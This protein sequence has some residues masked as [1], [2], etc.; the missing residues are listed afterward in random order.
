MPSPV[1]RET[2]RETA[3]GSTRETARETAREKARETARGTARE[4]TRETARESAR[5]TARPAASSAASDAPPP[6][7]VDDLEP[8]PGQRL[9]YLQRTVV[10]KRR[11]KRDKPAKRAKRG[12]PGAKRKKTKKPRKSR[13]Q[14]QRQQRSQLFAAI[15]LL[16]W[17]PPSKLSCVRC[18][19]RGC[20][21]TPLLVD[22]VAH[23]QLHLT[24]IR[25]IERDDVKQMVDLMVRKRGKQ[26]CSQC[27][28]LFGYGALQAD[29]SRQ[30]CYKCAPPKT[31]RGTITDD[32]SAQDHED[33]LDGIV[34]TYALVAKA[35][36]NRGL[37][38]QLK[39]E[40]GQCIKHNVW[41]MAQLRLVSE[42]FRVRSVIAHLGLVLCKPVRGTKAE[43]R[44]HTVTMMNLWK[45]EQY[46]EVKRIAIELAGKHERA[47]KMRRKRWQKR[48]RELAKL[49]YEC[50]DATKAKVYSE[51]ADSEPGTAAD[52]ERA[53]QKKLLRYADI[54]SGGELRKV[55]QAETSFGLAS[56]KKLSSEGVSVLKLLEDRHPKRK[57][58]RGDEILPM[59]AVVSHVRSTI[60]AAKE[61]R[62]L[63]LER[64][65]EDAK[66]RTDETRAPAPLVSPAPLPDAHNL[67]ERPPLP[68]HAA[69]QHEKQ[70]SAA[71]RLTLDVLR[72]TCKK[73]KFSTAAG[74]DG[75]APWLY[76]QCVLESARDQVG[77]LLLRVAHRAMRGE[78]SLTGGR[79]EAI[80]LLI[81]LW[82]DVE[83]TDVRPIAIACARRRIICKAIAST[84]KAEFKQLLGNHQAGV[85]TAGF[86]AC[87]HGM[88]AVCGRLSNDVADEILLCIDFSN[89][90][91]SANRATMLAACDALAPSLT[92]LVHWL[93]AGT[94]RVIT[95]DGDVIDSDTGVQQGDCCA[96]LLFGALIAYLDAR[97]K[98]AFPSLN[99]V[100]YWDDGYLWA[101]PEVTAKALA[102]LKELEPLT[103]LSI[104]NDKCAVHVPAD[105]P[106]LLERAK[107]AFH[108]VAPELPI[109]QHLNVK[110]LKQ[111]VGTK[112]WT[113]HQLFEKLSAWQPALSTYS[114]LAKSHPHQACAL[115]QHCCGQSKAVH[116]ARTQPPDFCQRFF[117]AW[118]SMQIPLAEAILAEDLGTKP[119]ET[120]HT[121]E[122][123]ALPSVFGG[124]DVASGRTTH[125][126]QFVKGL[127]KSAPAVSELFATSL[128]DFNALE[129]AMNGACD[130]ITRTTGESRVEVSRLIAREFTP[131]G[132]ADHVA[133]RLE[134]TPPANDVPLTAETLIQSVWNAIRA[135]SFAAQRS[136]TEAY[137]GQTIADSLT[138][139]CLRVERDRVFANA[140]AQQQEHMCAHSD[141]LNTWMRVMPLKYKGYL[142]NAPILRLLGIRCQSTQ[143]Q[144]HIHAPPTSEDQS[145]P[146]AAQEI[147]DIS[148]AWD[149]QQPDEHLDQKFS[150]PVEAEA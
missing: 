81:G 12:G 110:V 149:L 103:G 73:V 120:S 140:T 14:R 91:N 76:A 97:L 121:W 85:H 71:R 33:F 4:A 41:Q 87:V 22:C 52:T 102:L 66:G 55:T 20:D 105:R 145:F 138:G 150:Q 5:E 148:R 111:P 98:V 89:A 127:A 134:T 117:C 143:A 135:E 58:G 26:V 65:D 79:A 131:R 29:E 6:S 136:A 67:A 40:F 42:E 108:Q 88:R 47:R 27:Y 77:K 46:G 21:C 147:V 70:A 107:T 63:L 60:D 137:K 37:P 92:G 61:I 8:V 90:F 54:I 38:Q 56:S 101:T 62:R 28:K 9:N 57:Y 104:R 93:Y 80:G 35:P 13:N 51:L 114:K 34:R 95:P 11:V 116:V 100:W 99:T 126:A 7:E 15:D 109:H 1:A 30:K 141:A 32:C 24:E 146:G 106:D 144:H 2:A 133:S 74:P 128:P 75:I 59:P 123:M 69:A 49:C 129:T 64:H 17:V 16:T 48:M 84:Y 112:E 139:L 18:P 132:V 94:S 50:G 10:E 36:R 96:N 72:A 118:D 130:S 19:I 115:L 53:E 124:C 3:R 39:V 43:R 78:Y 113:E 45:A 122:R 86:E 44:A 125:A 31:A 25:D 23:A 119:G 142:L 83:Q 68:T 82:K